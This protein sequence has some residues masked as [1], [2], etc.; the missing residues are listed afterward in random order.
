VLPAVLAVVALVA[1]SDGASTVALY[2][3][4]AAVPFAAVSALVAFGDAV[5]AR[6]ETMVAFQ[7]LLWGLVALLL[8]LSCALRSQAVVVP[9]LAT[10]A[11]V[12]CLALFAVKAVLAAPPVL[13]RLAALRPAKP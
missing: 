9:P 4:L 10:S 5:E 1:D 2:A 7:A 3:L 12:A 13:R 8:V 6:E 11:V